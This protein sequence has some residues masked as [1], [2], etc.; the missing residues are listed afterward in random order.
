[1][2]RMISNNKKETHRAGS[3]VESIRASSGISPVIVLVGI[4]FAA[5]YPSALSGNF[6]SLLVYIPYFTWIILAES[7]NVAGGYAG[8]L[9][10]G[11]VGSFALGAF[12]TA[13]AMSSG[14]SL[15]PSMIFGGVA[16]IILAVV[17]IPTFRLRSDYFAIATLVVPFMLKPIIEAVFPTTSFT[18]P[19]SEALTPIELY[20]FGLVLAAISIFAVYVLMRSRAG[21]ALRAIGENEI[22]SS[23][24]GVN[25]LLYKTVAIVLSGFFAAVAGGFFFQYIAIDSNLFLNL[26]YSLFPI[27]MVIIGGIGTFEGP[28]VGA[29]LFSLISY[30]LNNDFPGTTYD[31]L[32]F[33]LVIMIV[34]VLLPKGIVPFARKLVRRLYHRIFPNAIIRPSSIIPLRRKKF[35]ED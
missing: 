22:A 2:I 1:M 16:G 5:A 12:I 35:D 26:N 23:S 19:R 34:A 27:F 11:L 33:S 4:L 20:Y 25:I 29:L 7:W 31:V 14:F 18:T 32:I 28:I 15:F 10:L 8:L 30:A 9:N 6:N 24:L 21:M 17:L 13:L 3:L